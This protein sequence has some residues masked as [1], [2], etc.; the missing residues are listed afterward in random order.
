MNRI[1][2]ETAQKERK[3][4]RVRTLFLVACGRAGAADAG[5]APRADG[6]ATR[7]RLDNECAR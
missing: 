1:S 5:A 3:Q 2:A 6:A 4:M 7:G